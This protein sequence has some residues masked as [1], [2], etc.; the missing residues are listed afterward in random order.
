M[1]A[2]IQNTKGRNVRF[3]FIKGLVQDLKRVERQKVDIIS[4]A[5]ITSEFFGRIVT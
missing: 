2:L 3:A 1:I 5:P 4:F